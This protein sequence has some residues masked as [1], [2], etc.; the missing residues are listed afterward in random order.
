MFRI[1]SIE[2]DKERNPD[3]LVKKWI[4]GY[5][6]GSLRFFILHLLQHRHKNEEAINT[7]EHDN[8]TL[9]GYHIAQIIDEITEG[10]WRPKTASIYPILREL[11]ENGVLEKVTESSNLESKG[12]RISIKY[13][14]TSFGKE[15][16]SK[17]ELARMEFTRPFIEQQSKFST[18]PLVLLIRYH[19]KQK[20]REY[21]ENANITVL[22]TY[23]KS[24]I[25]DITSLKEI[26]NLIDEEKKKK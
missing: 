26:L 16:A 20:L 23:Q 6:R 11:T 10:K 5:R 4:R 22:D 21:L 18:K 25:E 7:D 13:R 2:N 19:G 17:L 12:K 1:L 8:V 9:Y 24:M 3:D 14:L 15:V